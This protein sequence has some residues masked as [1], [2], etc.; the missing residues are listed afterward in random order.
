M[1]V[2]KK[3]SDGK[4]KNLI[5]KRRSVVGASVVGASVEGASVVGAS[6][7]TKYYNQTV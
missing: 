5:R 2:V 7:E 1:L 6:V 3:T 4:V